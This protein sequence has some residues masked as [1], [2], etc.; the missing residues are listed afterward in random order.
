MYQSKKT[1]LIIC[2]HEEHP[3]GAYGCFRCIDPELLQNLSFMVDKN[4]VEVFSVITADGHIF[5][6]DKP[7]AKSFFNFLH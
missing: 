2:N 5:K 6:G 7:D 1:P 4:E 3:T